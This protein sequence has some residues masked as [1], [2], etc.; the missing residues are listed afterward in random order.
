MCQEYI[1]RNLDL[2]PIKCFDWK[3][4]I[5]LFSIFL[6]VTFFVVLFGA[7]SSSSSLNVSEVCETSGLKRAMNC[8][9]TKWSLIL[10]RQAARSCSFLSVGCAE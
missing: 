8:S 5:V 2:L 7:F 6:F 10:S 9:Q 4:L 3:V 1:Y